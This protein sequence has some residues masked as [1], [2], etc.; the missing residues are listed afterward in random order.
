M[1]LRPFV[2]PLLA[3]TSFADAPVWE[4]QAVFRV[5]KEAPRATSIPFPSRDAGL[6]KPIAESPWHH[7]LNDRPEGPVPPGET[8]EGAW[9]FHY[10]GNPSAV[11]PRF[12][13]P[14]FDVSGW[15]SIPVPA[16]WQMHGYGI[17]L[18]TNSEYP[19]AVD[20][21][22][23]MGTPPA[24]FTNFPEENR[25]PVGCYRRDF[26]LPDGWDGR[27]TFLVFN[28]VDSAF[29]LWIN[30][31][32]VG[33]SQDSRTPAEFEITKYLQDG[34]NTLAVQVFQYSDGSYLED[35]DMWRLSGIF[36]DV[37][38]WS[39]AP[40]QVRDFWVKAGLADDYETGTLEIEADI[41]HLA[42]KAPA[43]T[44]EFELIDD[45][46]TLASA[47][48]PVAAG[49][50]TLPV[51]N[52]PAIEPWSAEIPR[53]YDYALTLK[54]GD[55][56][57]LAVH[58]GRT[59]FRRNEVKDGNFLHN[60]KPVLIKGVNR[61]DHHP[62]TG[63]YVTEKDMRDDLLQM[64]RGNIN[65]VRCS[66]YPNEPRFYELCDELGM[67][68]VDE[69]NI[70]SHG[71]G[72]G[73]DANSIAKDASW[74]PAHLDRMKN[75]LERD[76]NHP[77][78]IMWSMGNESGDGVNF[79]EMA[80]WIRQRDPFRPVHYEQAQQR[81]HVDL[82]VPMYAPVD[83]CVQYAR[84]QEKKPLAEQRPMIQC[85]Y[86]HAM[87]NSSGNLA[88]YWE[89]FRSERLLQGGF[90][91]DWKD[92]GLLTRKHALDAVEDRSDHDHAT[93]LLGSLSE[94]EGLFGGA[95]TVDDSDTLDLTE[96][97]TLVVEARGN[98]GGA[99]AQGGGDNNRNASD[100]YPLVTKGDTAY[101]IKVDASGTRLEFFVYTDTWQTLKADLPANWRSEFHTLIG[102]YDGRV[103]KIFVD[104]KEAASKPVTGAISTNDFDLGIGTN[105]EKPAR[106][107]DGSIRK[108]AVYPYGWTGSPK[109]PA[110]F[111][112]DM[113]QDASKN[114][115]RPLFAYGGDYNDR[116]SQRSFCLNGIVLPSLAPSP[117]FAEVTKVHQDIHVNAVDLSSPELKLEIF[118]ERFFRPLD[119]VKA[120]WKLLKDG[121]PAA[122]GTLALPAIGP[123]VT[124][125]VTIPTNVT[126]D[127]KAE[128]LIRLR[129]DLK[130]KTDWHPAGFPLAWDELP[131][132]WGQRTPPAP[133][134]GEGA[135]TFSEEDGAILIQHE[136]FSARI[137]GRSGMLESWTIG[138]EEL[139]AR[140]MQLD[141]WRPTTNNDEGA[142]FPSRLAVW[143]EAGPGATARSL[144]ARNEDDTVVV[145][146]MLT[147]PAGQ[148]TAELR[149]IFRPSG[150]IDVEAAFSPKGG[151]LP[152]IPRVGLRA[153]IQ[154][155]NIAWRW[156]GLGPHE[157]Y[158]DR[159][160]GSWTAVHTGITPSLFHRYL[161]PQ[162]AGVRTEVRWATF[163]SP[164][165]GTGLRI[166]ALGDDLLDIAA[167]P[168]HP[169]DVELARHPVD[170]APRE[171]ITLRI[172]HRSTGLGGTN[173]WGQW[174]LPKYRI[175]PKGTYRWAFRLGTERT[176]APTATPRTLPRRVPAPTEEPP[177]ND[178]DTN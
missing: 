1:M 169:L 144:E 58:S 14:D 71:M 76:K 123:Q 176:P 162:E 145:D 126:P 111:L 113:A 140:P 114:P 26:T 133:A 33:Y 25:N 105:T 107:F 178:D 153:G 129:F 100:G 9:K 20:P 151:G 32:H 27:H 28:G 39:S 97:V 137:G 2:L 55:G 17:P 138:E 160:S 31:K 93:R 106:K 163:T 98:F 49:T 53:L 154:P 59:G 118:N 38:L 84:E 83:R 90:I 149:W 35:Q 132:P 46:R 47:S 37:Y 150:E 174:P 63:H 148:S 92:Q 15:K 121:L 13:Q 88:D 24:H 82:F 22:R 74:G 50:L 60:G 52:L 101:S 155:A 5:N 109:A 146:S 75:C 51:E 6:G 125:A 136:D 77:S 142:G 96:A 104:G 18:Y 48:A 135:I 127:P 86:N 45:G 34:A 3:A 167:M 89:V 165:G 177:A 78:I 23:V 112:A 67:Y 156:H 41:R 110:A 70:E 143:R 8:F 64:K 79:R 128:W 62:V 19:F 68:V 66:H 94:E 42:G 10:V 161:D 168:C 7:S 158:E 159:R 95:V 173:S 134:E 11:P 116:P 166:D 170:L 65:A 56:G 91:W 122:S 147:V 141:F 175:E 120:S 152:I 139:L 54:D 131:L 115:T 40:L 171:D 119:D 99:R 87:G 102:S 157:N 164:M 172:D 73:P 12:P 130:E 108:V 124:H 72:W 69:A 21:P 80:E 29:H 16:N 85:E 117:Q 30:G 57:I 103:M 81:P 61:H 4:D 44:L 43:G 36:R